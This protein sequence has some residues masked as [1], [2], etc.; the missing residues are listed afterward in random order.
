MMLTQKTP[1]TDLILNARINVFSEAYL[2]ELK[3]NIL[4]SP[5]IA[6]SSL[7][8]Q[9]FSQSK[10]FSCITTPNTAKEL[11][12]FFPYFDQYLATALR[13]DCNVYYINA[14]LISKGAEVKM[15]VDRSLSK[16]FHPMCVTVMYVQI[17][18]G[19]EGGELFLQNS[20]NQKEPDLLIKPKE[21]AMI[22]FRGDLLH[23]V[24]PVKSELVR[25]SLVCEQYQIPTD[26]LHL[27]PSLQ[28]PHK[29]M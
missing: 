13:S 21:N 25:V 22:T 23:G 2:A 12:F 4:S 14:L 28:I 20:P 11:C 19:A 17:D 24:L 10:G 29:K 5:Y 9:S 3:R 16:H 8:Y 7:S 26:Q 1:N 15:H 18:E 27:V 6:N